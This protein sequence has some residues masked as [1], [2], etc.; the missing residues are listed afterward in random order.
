MQIGALKKLSLEIADTVEKAIKK[1]QRE[2]FQEFGK[3]VCDGADGTPTQWIDKYAEDVILDMVGDKRINILSEELGWMDKGGDFTLV[4][5]PIDGTRN[6]VY[7]IPFYAL[8]IAIGKKKLG[9]VQYGLVR[10]IPTG[11]TYSAEIGKGAFLNGVKITVCPDFSNQIISPVLGP[12][13]DP[14]T[15]SLIQQYNIRSMGSAAL[16]MCLVANGSVLAYLMGKESLRSTDIAAATLIVREAGGEVYNAVGEVLDMS[17]TL[18][19][20]TSVLA[21]SS[22]KLREVLL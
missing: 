17:L 1:K 19:E 18:K 15:W 16:E 9:D 6:A 11:D 7:N 5:D 14:K 12:S 2:N 22:P 21:V 13:G 3:Y 8:S 4:L 10:N 20:R